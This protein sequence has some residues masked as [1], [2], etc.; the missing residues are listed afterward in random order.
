MVTGPEV[1][2]A[3]A[4]PEVMETVLEVEKED[5]AEEKADPEVVEDLGRDRV[6]TLAI[7]YTDRGRVVIAESGQV[8]K[9]TGQE[10]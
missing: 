9:I 10:T 6:I 7:I 8:F 2:M 5:Q 3:K 4:D 1:E